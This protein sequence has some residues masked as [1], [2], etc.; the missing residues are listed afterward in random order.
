MRCGSSASGAWSSRSGFNNSRTPARTTSSRS[1]STWKPSSTASANCSTSKPRRRDDRA[2][3]ADIAARVARMC[4]SDAR[5]AEFEERLERE[6]LA[7]LMELAYGAG[8]EINNPL[9]NIAARAQTLL[10]DEGDPE[11]R[12]KVAAIHPP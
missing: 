9:A 5:S 4:D 2:T 6:K 12:R 11:R 8:H 7:A 3:R 1:R 10:A